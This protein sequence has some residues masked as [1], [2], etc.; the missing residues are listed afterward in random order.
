MPD[1]GSWAGPLKSE[2]IPNSSRAGRGGEGEQMQPGL[3]ELGLS[4]LN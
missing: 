2:I 4:F 1:P 3:K